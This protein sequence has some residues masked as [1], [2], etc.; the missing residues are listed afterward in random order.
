MFAEDLPCPA[1]GKV[2][3]SAPPSLPGLNIPLEGDAAGIKTEALN[4]KEIKSCLHVVMVYLSSVTM[5]G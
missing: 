2:Y 3:I 1:W 4:G 5:I